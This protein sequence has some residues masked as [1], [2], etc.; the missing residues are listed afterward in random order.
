MMRGFDEERSA[1]VLESFDE[2]A[3]AAVTLAQEEA[4][5]LGHGQAGTGHLLLALLGDDEGVA[6]R[7]L[8][9]LGVTPDEVR[10]RITQV[11]GRGEEGSLERG[12]FNPR[13]ARVL[14]LA[15]REAA[16]AGRERVGGGHL[17][18]GLVREANS[19][20]VR[21]LSALDASPA[22]VR[23]E[24]TRRLHNPSR[25]GRDETFR[26]AAQVARPPREAP[27]RAPEDAPAT[28]F[29]G[30]VQALEVHARCGVSE[31]E[32]A[33]PQALLVDLAYVY[34]ARAADDASATVDY[35]A[36]LEEAAWALEHEEFR[37]LEAGAGRIGER[38]LE[39]FPAVRE[40]A[41][42]VTKPHVPVARTVAGVSVRTAFRR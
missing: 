33:L 35:G 31:E 2:E 29:R 23:R 27:D 32:R 3:R 7:A 10:E 4:A 19:V 28:T 25:S 26:H 8:V 37:L 11:G 24:V 16:R 6:A 21:V 9:A 15:P 40:V 20:A 17:L 30:R 39:R 41:V 34:E 13:L 18:L 14:E 38:V 5:R 36:L 12:P 42:T 1:A 22:D